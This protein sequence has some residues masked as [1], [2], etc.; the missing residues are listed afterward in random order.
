MQLHVLIWRLRSRVWQLKRRLRRSLLAL[1]PRSLSKVLSLLFGLA[2][3]AY[4]LQRFPRYW[5]S[6]EAFSERVLSLCS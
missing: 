4:L 1:L 2:W 5:S 6:W 3:L